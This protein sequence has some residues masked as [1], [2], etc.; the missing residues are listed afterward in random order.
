MEDTIKI[1]LLTPLAG[2]FI[3]N[4]MERDWEEEEYYDPDEDRKSVV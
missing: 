1:E 2:T 3:P 4:E